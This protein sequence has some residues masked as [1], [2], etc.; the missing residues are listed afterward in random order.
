MTAT[1]KRRERSKWLRLRLKSPS[2]APLRKSNVGT[3]FL[4]GCPGK[5]SRRAAPRP[6]W[7]GGSHPMEKLI[8]PLLELISKLPDIFM[9]ALT[10]QSR[11]PAVQIPPAGP[12]GLPGSPSR[13][14][15][16]RFFRSGC[17]RNGAR[18]WFRHDNAPQATAL[19]TP[20]EMRTPNTRVDIPAAVTTLAAA[21]IAPT[22]APAAARP[23]TRTETLERTPMV[24]PSAAP[25]AA[26]AAAPAAPAAAPAAE[27]HLDSKE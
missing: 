11:T 4:G 15:Q 24:A 22:V 27:R 12:S 6:E 13:S 7:T 8:G 14:A 1:Q 20:D 3:V 9:A 16:C 5:F 26:T 23:S 18:C 21:L 2:D 25:A 17:C 19:P 10:S